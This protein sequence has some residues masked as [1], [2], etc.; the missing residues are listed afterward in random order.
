MGEKT[1][2]LQPHILGFSVVWQGLCVLQK[3]LNTVLINDSP[4]LYVIKY[5]YS[6]EWTT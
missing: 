5:V 4:L 2:I 3:N 6:Y 1:Y